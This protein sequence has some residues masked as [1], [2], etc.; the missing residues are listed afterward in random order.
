MEGMEGVRIDEAVATKDGGDHAAGSAV[1]QTSHLK[2][3]VQRRLMVE[4]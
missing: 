2:R 4:F 3:A 1:C